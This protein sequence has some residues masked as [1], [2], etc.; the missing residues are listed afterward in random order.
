MRPLEDIGTNLVFRLSSKLAYRQQRSLRFFVEAKPV[1]KVEGEVKP[2]I[3]TSPFRALATRKPWQTGGG[4][5]C[6]A[7]LLP[8]AIA[9][10]WGM[11]PKD[12]RIAPSFSRKGDADIR[13]TCNYADGGHGE[14]VYNGS[15]GSANR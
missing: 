4:L 3:N 9:S 8:A 14:L 5:D 15:L 10:P 7:R 13:Y 12:T 11:R 1:M 2:A 6:A